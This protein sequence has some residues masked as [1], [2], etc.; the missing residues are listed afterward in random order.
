MS[1]TRTIGPAEAAAL[2]RLYVEQHVMATN[3]TADEEAAIFANVPG[4]VVEPEISELGKKYTAELNEAT[5]RRLGNTGLTAAQRLQID[6]FATTGDRTQD[7]VDDFES[8]L[9]GGS[10]R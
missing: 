5:D 3:M 2:N 4:G 8:R 6:S 10:S 9:R 7:Q 1:K